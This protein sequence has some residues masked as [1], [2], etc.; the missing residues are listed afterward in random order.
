MQEANARSAVYK[1][2][3]AIGSS[4]CMTENKRLLVCVFVGRRKEMPIVAMKRYTYYKGATYGK[5]FF[6]SI[7]HAWACGEQIYA[8]YTTRKQGILF[9]SHAYIYCI[10]CVTFVVHCMRI[11]SRRWLLMHWSTRLPWIITASTRYTYSQCKPHAHL[12]NLCKW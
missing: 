9:T 3:W 8:I 11:K 6:V 2:D 7:T 5:A 12:H 10:T 1:Y 4:K